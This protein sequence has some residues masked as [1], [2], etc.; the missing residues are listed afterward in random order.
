[1]FRSCS[2]TGVQPAATEHPL[3][4]AVKD[5]DMRSLIYI[6]FLIIAL[7]LSACEPALERQTNDDADE[8]AV[9]EFLEVTSLEDQIEDGHLQVV[10]EVRNGAPYALEDVVALVDFLG[11]DGDT[12]ATVADSTALI[13][14][15]ERWLFE[16]RAPIGTTHWE[17]RGVSLRD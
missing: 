10:G 13:A 11:H 16:M 14:S 17:F 1:V 2:V 8:Q 9:E 15:G 12:L 7:L 5:V 6:P 4:P 3:G